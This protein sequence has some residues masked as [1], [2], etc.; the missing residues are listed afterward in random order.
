MDESNH[1]ESIESDEIEDEYESD[2]I[3][4]SIK[5]SSPREPKKKE[6]GKSNASTA[7]TTCTE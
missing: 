1:E 7:A 2:E 3:I 4:E 5:A 6:V